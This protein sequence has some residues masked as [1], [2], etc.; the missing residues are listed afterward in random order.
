MIRLLPLLFLFGCATIDMSRPPPADWPKLE[1]EIIKTTL[2]EA[3]RQ[4]K[5]VKLIVFGCAKVFFDEGVCRI[6]LGTED[7]SVYEH[8]LLHC[9]GYDHPGESTMRDAWAK[10]T[11]R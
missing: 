6:Y 10:W 1:V 11:F 2:D 5:G 9:K 3:K 4:C 8:E 7:K